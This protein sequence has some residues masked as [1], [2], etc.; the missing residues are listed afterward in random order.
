MARLEEGV[1]MTREGTHLLSAFHPELTG[2]ERI[3]RYF[4][5]MVR[6]DAGTA[7]REQGG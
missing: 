4:L 5:D 2:D 6:E 7:Q 3:H 1:V